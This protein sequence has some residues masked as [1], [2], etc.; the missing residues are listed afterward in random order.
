MSSNR[1]YLPEFRAEAVKQVLERGFKVVDVVTRIGV[2][3]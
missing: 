3:K 1:H 2:P